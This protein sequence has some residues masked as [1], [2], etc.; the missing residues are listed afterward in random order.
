M[1]Q[2]KFLILGVIGM[3]AFTVTAT[4]TAKLE[5][6][7]KTVLNYEVLFTI[8]AVSVV[9]EFNFVA[10]DAVQIFSGYVLPEK[11][12]NDFKNIL[13][14][15]ADV[16]WRRSAIKYT[17]IHYKEKLLENYNLNFITNLRK[18]NL[19]IRSDC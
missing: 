1:K 11:K 4:T 13:A 17:T 7:Q 9:N 16:G 8:E 5:E 12:E 14:I 6:K 2:I 15:V 18:Q 19:S 10:A 3:M